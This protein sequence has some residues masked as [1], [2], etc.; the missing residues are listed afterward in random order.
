[1]SRIVDEKKYFF[2]KRPYLLPD[3]VVNNGL[4]KLITTKGEIAL[5]IFGDHNLLNLN[6]ARL[7]CNE[8]GI[9]EEQFYIAIS[10][11]KGASRRLELIGKNENT[12]VYKDFAHSPSKLKATISAVKAQFPDRKLVAVIELH[13]FSSLNQEFLNEYS[14]SMD[15]A[16]E[17]IV[18][19]DTK[20]FYLKGIKPYGATI[21]K[22]S[23]ANEKLNFFNNFEIL[24]KFL[25][26]I[27]FK[28]K[29]LLLMSSGN[30]GGM[31][32]DKLKETILG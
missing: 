26:K 23:F 10:G 14:G 25:I 28:G 22:Q 21:V 19:V 29:N 4:T 3:R 31:N 11:F 18:F 2:T 16:D 8:L 30:F 6:A 13:T 17:S 9:S 15:E 5:E 7:V 24:E 1:M 32:L 20:T 27:N 12:A